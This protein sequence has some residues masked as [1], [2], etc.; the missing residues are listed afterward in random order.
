MVSAGELPLDN[1]LITLVLFFEFTFL[2]ITPEATNKK[3]ACSS[4]KFSSIQGII[5]KS[6]SRK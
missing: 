6:I 3:A 5:F 2:F 1:G 4:I